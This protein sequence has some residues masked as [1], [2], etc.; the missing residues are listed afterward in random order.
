[1]HYTEVIS[2]CLFEY[3]YLDENFTLCI[4]PCILMSFPYELSFQHVC[5]TS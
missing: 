5:Q 3:S 1:M 2:V 4:F